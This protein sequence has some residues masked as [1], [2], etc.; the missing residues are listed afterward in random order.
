MHLLSALLTAVRFLVDKFGHR[1]V[2]LASLV[3]MAGVTFITFFSPNV[4][5]LCA[6]QLLAGFPWGIFATTAPAFASECLPMVL[7]VY[8][9]SWTNMCFCIGQLIAAGVLRGLSSRSDEWAFRIPFAIQWVWIVLIGPIIYFTPSSPWHEVRKGRLDRAEKSLRR[10]QRASA[11]IDPKNTLAVIVMTNDLE[12]ELEIGTSYWDC[13]KSI[14]RRKTE[15]A[16]VC[17]MGQVLS[18]SN[19]ACK[20]QTQWPERID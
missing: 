20:F 4:G 8:L 2:L 14:E 7:R 15:I 6:G 1:K 5:V 10:L 3:A 18:G 17:F 12:K 19:F 9:T 16:C 11:E 13:F